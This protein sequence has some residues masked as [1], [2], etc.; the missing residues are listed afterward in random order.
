VYNDHKNDLK[1][2]CGRIFLHCAALA[3]IAELVSLPVIGRE[4]PFLIGLIGGT[5]TTMLNFRILV[6]SAERMLDLHS[7]GPVIG[8]YFLRLP[9]YGVVFFFS[10]RLGAHCATACVIGFL[11]LHLSILIIYGLE[12]HL[13]GARKNPLNSW[14]EPRQWRD[15]SEWEED[16]DDYT[17]L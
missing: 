12:S 8:G 17:D 14:T 4:L 2:F 15:P 5:L 11:T 6:W 10:L 9:I 16:D 1:S 7:R 3:A 13:P